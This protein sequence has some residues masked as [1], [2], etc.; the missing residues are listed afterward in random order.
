MSGIKAAG[1]ER[2]AVARVSHQRRE[3]VF[4]ET[5]RYRIEGKLTSSERGFRSSLRLREPGRPR[6]LRRRG[7]VG[8]A[9]RGLGETQAV[10]FMLVARR[11]MRLAL[12][13][14][15]DDA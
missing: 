2:L 5:D 9:A 1:D 10:G 11:H 3:P 4:L 6:L 7:G 14:P 13:V 8:H 15:A 12:P